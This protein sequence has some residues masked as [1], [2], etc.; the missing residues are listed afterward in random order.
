MIVDVSG[1]V[2][3]EFIIHDVPAFAVPK[4]TNK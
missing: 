4:E 1:F 2:P 3:S